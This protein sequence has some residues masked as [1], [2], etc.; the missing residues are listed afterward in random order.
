MNP[1]KTLIAQ[2]YSASFDRNGALEVASEQ[3]AVQQSLAQNAFFFETHEIASLSFKGKRL[4]SDPDNFSGRR[5]V[6]IEKLYTKEE[7][8]AQYQKE[9]GQ[10]KN[11]KDA[12]D[13]QIAREALRSV[14]G[15]YRKKYTEDDRFI[16]E[17]GFR[18][19]FIG[20][21]PSEKA[22]DRKGNQIWPQ[23]K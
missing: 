19:D 18:G 11:L 23:P 12:F 14:I 21:K 13:R 4:N 22:Y 7:V 8:I 9:L 5:F 17:P 3:D 1:K 6:G 20:L 15:E 16:A 10:V 2:F